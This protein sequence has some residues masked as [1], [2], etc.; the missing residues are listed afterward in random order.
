[1]QRVPEPL[2]RRCIGGGRATDVE[3]AQ[4]SDTGSLRGT[5]SA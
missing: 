1:V 4:L 5:W 3:L 2:E